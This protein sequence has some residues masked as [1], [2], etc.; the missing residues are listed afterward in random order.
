MRQGWVFVL[1]ALAVVGVVLFFLWSDGPAETDL[2]R[3]G[4]V[5]ADDPALV[6]GDLSTA[7]GAG[8]VASAGASPR[9][10]RPSL[11][12]RG[13]LRV[14]VANVVG[15]LV[16]HATQTPVAQA[17]LLLR[18]RGYAGEEVASEVASD[19]EG[20]FRMRDVAAGDDFALEIR[21]GESVE[22]VVEGVVL[23]AGRVCDLGTIWLGEVGALEGRVED[24][25]GKPLAKAEVRVLQGRFTQEQMM[26]DFVGFLTQLDRD[27]VAV[28]TGT[29][30]A[31]GRFRIEALPPGPITVIAN[32]PGH[33]QG[34]RAVEMT[35]G[36]AIGGAIV[37]HLGEAEPITGRVLDAAGHGVGKARVAFL[38]QQDDEFGFVGRKFVETGEDGSFRVDAPPPARSLLAIVAADGYPTLFA[39]VAGERSG[40]EFTLHGGATLG[41]SFLFDDTGKPVSDAAIV[42]MVSERE[43]FGESGT[44]LTGTTDGEGHIELPALPGFVGM[45]VLQHPEFGTSLYSPQQDMMMGNAGV[46]MEGPEKIELGLGRK[47]VEFRVPRGVAVHGRVTDPGGH[48]VAGAVV[49]TRGGLFGMGQGA[50]TLSDEEGKYRFTTPKSGQ[51]P[52]I[53]HADGYVQAPETRLVEVPEG[54]TELAHDVTLLPAAEVEGLVVDPAGAPLAGIEVSI[55]A[56]RGEGDVTFEDSFDFGEAQPVRAISDARGRFLLSNV[57]PGATYFLL[58]RGE[59]FVLSRSETF[60]VGKGGA[61]QRAPRLEL[62]R[63]ASLDVTVL[64]VSGVPLR[65]ADVEVRVERAD[66][67]TWSAQD[68]WTPFAHVATDAA[69]KATVDDLPAGTV[70]LVAHGD[71]A[72]PTRKRITIA[73]DAPPPPVVALQLRPSATLRGRVVDQHANPVTTGHLWMDTTLEVVRPGE[74]A[75]TQADAGWVQP[76]GSRV[77]AQGKFEFAHVPVGVTVELSF[78]ADGYEGTSMEVADV[79]S[80]VELV[81]KKLDPAVQELQARMMAVYR[82]MAQAKD[83]AERAALAAELEEIQAELVRLQ[84]K[85][86]EAD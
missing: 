37:L 72:A 11:F 69:G 52:V 74:Q 2:D 64:D 83:D 61:K 75:S 13:Q 36:G 66:G 49:S 16:D 57:A 80:P 70:T 63:G 51:V 30:D 35:A 23:E 15:R 65:G 53:A 5:A 67:L 71:D 32:A 39:E 18:G 73:A 78:N 20:R 42:V 12:G 9:S 47:D 62:A 48:P 86:A 56:D 79:W 21:R 34:A 59:G 41:L 22:R 31:A 38:D 46:L 76:Q 25:E 84:G 4:T 28:G 68:P 19:A 24:L 43:A 1:M 81:V 17:A 54:A 27:P 8:S 29:T 7:S 14:G 33:R 3:G 40:L 26:K 60:D 82:T 44:F 58:G 85:A 6:T 10:R 45:V 55:R 77:D 50:Q